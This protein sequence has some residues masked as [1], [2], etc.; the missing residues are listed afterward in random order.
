MS[1]VL[2]KFKCRKNKIQNFLKRILMR[3]A[4]IKTFEFLTCFRFRV[5]YFAF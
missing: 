2:N 4:T 1:E 5:Y 3:G